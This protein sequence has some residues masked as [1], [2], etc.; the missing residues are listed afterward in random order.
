MHNIIIKTFT[1]I[2]N[3]LCFYVKYMFVIL[4]EFNEN[5]STLY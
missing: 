1:N 4:F 5:Y 2:Y 3:E